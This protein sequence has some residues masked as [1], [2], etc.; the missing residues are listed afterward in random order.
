MGIVLK[1]REKP[2]QITLTPAEFKAVILCIANTIEDE[3][4][5]RAVNAM[6]RVLEKI[7]DARRKNRGV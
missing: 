4:D 2:I 7:Y 5:G 6:G 1:K 3:S